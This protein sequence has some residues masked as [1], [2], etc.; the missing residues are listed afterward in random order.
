VPGESAHL[1]EGRFS[2]TGYARYTKTL[3][4]LL[5]FALCC[6]VSRR[7][8]FREKS[9]EDASYLSSVKVGENHVVLGYGRERPMY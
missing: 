6:C 5:C 2:L 8:E 1:A 9:S 7:E 3:A 4:N